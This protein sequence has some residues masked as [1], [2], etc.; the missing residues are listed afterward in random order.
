VLRDPR[1]ERRLVLQVDQ[2][3]VTPQTQRRRELDA[4]V[5]ELFDATGQTYGSPRIHRDLLEA[6]WQVG[7]NTVADSMH[8]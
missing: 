7:E 1:P 2:G 6:G 5:R 4:K 8:R 3:P